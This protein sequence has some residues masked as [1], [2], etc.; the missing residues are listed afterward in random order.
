MYLLKPSCFFTHWLTLSKCFIYEYYFNYIISSISLPDSLSVVSG[1][2]E[3]LSIS[4][5][6]ALKTTV[7]LLLGSS[8]HQGEVHFQGQVI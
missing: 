5:H 1:C 7:V 4:D 8:C 2:G 3:L 6:L